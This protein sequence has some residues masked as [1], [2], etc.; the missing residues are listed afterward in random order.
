VLYN[1]PTDNSLF[2][3]NAN[4]AAVGVEYCFGDRIDAD[5]A[6]R[7]YLWV[8]AYTCAK[9]GLDPKAS[10]VG[11]FFLDPQRKTD[12]VTGLARSRRTYEQ[13]LKDVVV[14]YH[15]CTGIQLPPTSHFVV[16]TGIART[17]VRLNIRKGEP[18]TK[19]PAV[20]SVIPGTQLVFSGWEENGE[21]VNN[22]S[23]WY[24]TA[25]GNYFWGG[26]VV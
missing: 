3:F 10:V 2:G 17:T 23:K 22:I 9:F 26:G 6:Y 21:S 5:E 11:H 1:V 25:E 7:K 24:K 18:N 8:I 19:A 14:E 4:D 20:Q 15:D 16:Q 13:L 12:P